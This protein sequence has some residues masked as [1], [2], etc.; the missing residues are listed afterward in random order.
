MLAES[1]K[2][3]FSGS[4]HAIHL[5]EDTYSFNCYFYSFDQPPPDG[6]GKILEFYQ[7]WQRKY[8]Q[9]YLPSWKDFSIGDFVGWHSNMRLIKCGEKFDK[10]DEVK[11]VGEKFK[12]YWG[13]KS[14]SELIREGYPVSPATVKK[15][16]E[17]LECLYANHYAICKG[18]L[19]GLDISVRPIWFID[20]PL[21]K[22]GVDITH[23][24]GAIYPR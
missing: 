17:Y 4:V 3:D 24:L 21:S 9:D 7:I 6:I 14:L 18:T 23:V 19:P 10:K 5:S 13:K 22:N 16:K 2:V 1:D 15:F 20:L 12:E 8:S 11:I